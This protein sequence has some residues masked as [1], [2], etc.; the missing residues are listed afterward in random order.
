[1]FSHLNLSSVPNVNYCMLALLSFII[2]FYSLLFFMHFPSNPS[3]HLF[4]P[5]DVILCI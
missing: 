4:N 2:V 5:V 3:A 1:M